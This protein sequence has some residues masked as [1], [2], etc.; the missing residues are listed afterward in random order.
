[1][2]EWFF[3]A[4]NAQTVAKAM[5]EP[6][7]EAVRKRDLPAWQKTFDLLKRTHYP[8][9][10][11]LTGHYSPMEFTLVD[12]CVAPKFAISR[13]KIPEESDF[14]LRRTLQTFVEFVSPHR[15]ASR[16]TRVRNR[17]MEPGRWEKSL[18]SQEDREE[19]QLF[20]DE[21]IVR[22]EK[23]PD[24]FWCLESNE[25]ADC[26]YASPEAVARM[27]EVE[28]T[29]GLFRRLVRRTD[30]DEDLHSLTR[31]LA[32]AGFLIELAASCGYALYFR[33]DGT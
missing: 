17:V 14:G 21:I 5:L 7:Q 4:F 12:G 6:A 10:V 8:P 29:V 33:E 20:R 13:D 30:L 25:A 26:N 22:R 1:M 3:F 31:D 18:V 23:L 28:S 2:P 15:I 16:R 24:P 9:H 27:A 11:S 19:M 32:T